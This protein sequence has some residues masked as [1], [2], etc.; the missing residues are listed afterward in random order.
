MRKSI[1]NL[2]M[3][4]GAFASGGGSS[5]G[6]TGG[7]V[8]DF[9]IGD[10]N[11]HIWVSIIDGYTAP[12]LKIVVNGTVTVDWGDGTAPDVLTTS[13]S[14][15]K[16]ITHEYS[17]DGDYI[18]TLTVDGELEFN[19][20]WWFY[21]SSSNAADSVC[22]VEVKKVECGHGTSLVGATFGGM[23]SLSDIIIPEGVT[24]IG[25][26]MCSSLYSLI[27]V[28][29]PEGVTSIGRSAFTSCSSL[30]SVSMPKSVTSIGDMAFTNCVGVSYYDFTKHTT[31]PALSGTYSFMNIASDCEIR[32][33]AALVD[34]WKAATN[35]SSV[36]SKIV[37]V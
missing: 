9:P 23:S 14:T 20:R 35:W 10:G 3:W 18:I 22:R 2:L 36:A 17:K 1:Y 32:V 24:S 4:S 21:S 25:D 13:V 16:D 8:A 26:S 28:D 19:G 34:E 15:W 12:R 30:P 29:I 37:G 33:P 11:T 5:G 6:G 7:G 31:V 27:R